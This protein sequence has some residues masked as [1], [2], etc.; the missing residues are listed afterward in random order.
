MKIIFA[1]TPEFAVDYLSA[2]LESPHEI[3]AVLTQPDKPAG[4][5]QHLTKSSVKKLALAHNLPIHQPTTLKDETI[6]N[7]LN[8]LNAD[9]FIDVAYGLLVPPIILNMFRFGCINVHPSLLPRFRGASPIQSAILEGDQETGITIMQMDEGLDTGSIL[10][11][12]K[13]PISENETASD[14]QKRLSKLGIKILIQALDQLERGKIHPKKQEEDQASYSKKIQKSDAK[15]D[16]EKTAVQIHREIRAFNPCPISYTEIDDQIIRIWQATP[17][18]HDAN[19]KP[20]KIINLSSEGLD[21]ATGDGILRIQRM[22][23]PGGK[24]LDIAAIL[25]SKKDF[26]IKHNY[27]R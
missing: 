12:E 20:G 26:F 25:N 14:L 18:D 7:T 13:Y 23:F 22:Q 15:I 9:V 21:V 27:F 2:L 6:Q 17:L 1:G 11:Q 3:C 8:A 16:W 10:L 24:P 5:G 19:E 4:R